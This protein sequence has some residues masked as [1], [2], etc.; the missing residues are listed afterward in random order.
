MFS[1]RDPSNCTRSWRPK[2]PNYRHRYPGR[3]GEEEEQELL[4]QILESPE[5]KHGTAH[6]IRAH[7][8]FYEGRCRSGECHRQSA[9]GSSNQINGVNEFVTILHSESRT[10]HYE[11]ESVK[12][13]IMPHVPNEKTPKWENAWVIIVWYRPSRRLKGSKEKFFTMKVSGINLSR[14]IS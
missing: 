7:F 1:W 5:G 6:H 13:C 2:N 4:P 10:K 8:W 3:H 14:H 9:C 12:G 11:Q